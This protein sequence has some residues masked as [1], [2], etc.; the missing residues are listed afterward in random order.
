MM[1]QRTTRLFAAAFIAS[2]VALPAACNR[3][4]AKPEQFTV[5]GKTVGYWIDVLKTPNSR[6]KDRIKAVRALGNVGD[7]APAA[8]PALIAALDDKD[9]KVR[10]E[11]VLA[12]G[13]SGTNA[14]AAVP[15]LEELTRDSDKRVSG[16][17]TK[18]LPRLKAD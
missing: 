11:A 10:A 16:Y 4:S 1:A 6:V 12:V 7:A 8:L 15:R 5:S 17:A 14:A 18:I 3:R 13:K 2:L 9:P